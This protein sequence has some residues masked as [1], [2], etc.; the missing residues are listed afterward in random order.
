MPFVVV[1]VG[2]LRCICKDSIIGG[3]SFNLEYKLDK[4]QMN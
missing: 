3:G 4:G 2:G 1:G